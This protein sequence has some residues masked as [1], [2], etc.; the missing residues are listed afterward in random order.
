MSSKGKDMRAMERER[1]NEE[2]RQLEIEEQLLLEKFQKKKRKIDQ[3]L[4]LIDEEEK[5][6]EFQ[7]RFEELKIES[8]IST[9]E[10]M[11]VIGKASAL[12]MEARD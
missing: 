3:D 8:T 5:R 12:C 4:A 11:D 7:D 1:L 6:I 2:K 10:A 9:E